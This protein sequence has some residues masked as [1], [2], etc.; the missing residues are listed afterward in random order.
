[1]DCLKGMTLKRNKF[2]LEIQIKWKQGSFLGYGGDKTQ[3]YK[4]YIYE[5]PNRATVPVFIQKGW[6][7]H[8]PIIIKNDLQYGMIDG[9]F[10]LV[11]HDKSQTPYQHRFLQGMPQRLLHSTNEFLKNVTNGTLDL[12]WAV[13]E[14]LHNFWIL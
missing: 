9:V 2:E 5:S 12:S 3:S 14:Y 10:F 11:Y 1:M 7:A 13:G 6:T 4:V 8:D